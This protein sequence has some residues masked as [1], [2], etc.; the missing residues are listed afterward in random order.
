MAPASTTLSEQLGR[1]SSA[2][3][4]YKWLILAIIAVGSS[5]GFALTRLVPPKY[6]VDGSI[7]I[8]K[9]NPGSGPISAPGLISDPASWV[10]L[11]RSFIVLDQVVQRLGLYVEPSNSREGP[12]TIGRAESRALSTQNR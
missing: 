4:R 3:R 9:S 2:I 11:T 10:D 1:F 7:L 8:R 5:I 12:E 6:R